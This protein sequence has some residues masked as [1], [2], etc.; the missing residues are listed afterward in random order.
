[1]ITQKI[2]ELNGEIDQSTIII[3]GFNTPPSAM[4]EQKDRKSVRNSTI[5]QLRLI[6]IY[7][8]LH[9]TKAENTLLSNEHRP[10]SMTDHV[11]D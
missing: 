3:E 9:P 8:I 5:H 10:V 11:L 1:M 7:R 6:G 4:I 2:V